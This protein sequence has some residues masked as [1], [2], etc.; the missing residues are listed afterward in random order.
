MFKKS[1]KNLFKFKKYYKKEQKLINC[2]IIV[3]IIASSMGMLLPYFFSQRLINI[4][5]LNAELVFKFSII[6]M[7]IISIHHLNWYL[8][9][10]LASLLTN[11]VSLSIRNDLTYKML[12]TTYFE[13]KSKTSGYYLERLND[14]V[15]TVSSFLANILGTLIDTLTNFSFLG[16]IYIL[17][18]KSGLIFTIG[19][20][21]LYIIDSIRINKEVKY[22]EKLKILN[23]KYSSKINENY[24]GIKDIKCLGIKNQIYEETNYFSSEISMI[25]IKMEKTIALYN[26][27]KTYLQYVLELILII[28]SVYVL[29]PN[30][31][32][33]IVVLLM[34]IDY[35]GFM[36]E[37]VGFIAKIKEQL[38]KGE[39]KASRLLEIL[40][41]QNIDQFGN[42]KNKIKN[43]FI[44]VHNL[45]YSY[46]DEPKKKVLKNISFE[47]KENTSNIFIGSSGSGKS[48][49]FGILTKLFE[50]EN[51]KVLIGNRDI[52]D[53]TEED[54]RE[55][56][57]V[58]NQEIFML[59]DSILNNIK[60]VKPKA[61]LNEIISVCKK[62]NIYEEIINL[63]E[64]FNTLITENGNNLSGGQKQ[65]IAIARSILKNCPILLFDE[66]TSALD[67]N[68]QKK[69]IE[70][71]NTLKK[72]KTILIITHKFENLESIDNVFELINGLIVN[73]R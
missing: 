13:I 49:L 34:I 65:R 9:E 32:L 35:S 42:A 3:M 11:N 46:P 28:Y 72:E 59:N 55:K 54:L 17:N 37:L 10:K 67:I 31:K 56:I 26:R 21:I 51:G 6:I 40:E 48:T 44:D 5:I 57:F 70:I 7:I 15:F 30:N 16:L 61:S 71:I 14:D 24:K 18:F 43:N 36:Y 69:F 66:P 19:I 45:S 68:N 8:W 50:I 39:L 33:S 63:K 22:I 27:I 47:I 38:I 60:I 25:T 41:N 58:V 12:N 64:G 2:L 4:T 52:N 53:F 1:Y 29:I 23:E 62:A 73:R 20:I